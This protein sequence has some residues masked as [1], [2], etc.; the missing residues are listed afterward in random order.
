V[1]EETPLSRQIL[2]DTYIALEADVGTALGDW[3]ADTGGL[4]YEGGALV[5]LLALALVAGLY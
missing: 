5:F 3:M 2:L 4:G 1:T